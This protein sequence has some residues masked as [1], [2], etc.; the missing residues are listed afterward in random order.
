MH[1]HSVFGA[2]GRLATKLIS[3]SESSRAIVASNNA[4]NTGVCAYG[5]PFATTLGLYNVSSGNPAQFV[6]RAFEIARAGGAAPFETSIVGDPIQGCWITHMAT[7]SRDRQAPDLALTG[8]PRGCTPAQFIKR[9][10]DA[11]HPGEPAPFDV[12]TG[13]GP[14]LALAFPRRRDSE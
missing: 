1:R 9:A 7:A 11:T 6:K 14:A 12:A 2:I 3:S 10:F 5:C 13:G 4:V 8:C